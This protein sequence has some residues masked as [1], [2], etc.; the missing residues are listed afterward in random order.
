MRNDRFEWDDE[1]ARANLAKHGV[2]FEEA[3]LVFDDP[4]YVVEPDESVFYEE[5]WRTT[6]LAL[7]RVLFVVSTE[8]NG[9]V[10]RII[11]AR[12][13]TRHEENRYYRQAFPEG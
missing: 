4:N 5:R 9:N 6:G 10:I 11:S 12:T 1:K 13:A 8:R 7:G 3:A 2:S